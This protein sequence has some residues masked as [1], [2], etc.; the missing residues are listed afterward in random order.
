MDGSCRVNNYTKGEQG[1][2]PRRWKKDVKICMRNEKAQSSRTRIAVGTARK[3]DV[4]HKEAPCSSDE[5]SFSY[6]QKFFCC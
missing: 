3:H 2:R 5:S 4:P 1:A 6:P